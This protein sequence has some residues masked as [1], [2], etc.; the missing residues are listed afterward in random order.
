MDP[1]QICQVVFGSISLDNLPKDV[2]HDTASPKLWNP[3]TQNVRLLYKFAQRHE[4]Y[5]CA[6]LH[7]GIKTT[8]PNYNVGQ[9]FMWIGA[10]NDQ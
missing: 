9:L 3:I 4:E 5:I 1:K 7:I 6:K 10:N 2:C 8:L